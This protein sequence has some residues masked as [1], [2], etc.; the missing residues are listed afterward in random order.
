MLLN[1]LEEHFAKTITTAMI[2]EEIDSNTSK[3]F[4]GDRFRK[5]TGDHLFT[6][7][8]EKTI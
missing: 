2:L 3:V 4:K 5:F 1:V 6:N 7:G 8:W